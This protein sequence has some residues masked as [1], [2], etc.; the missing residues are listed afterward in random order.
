MQKVQRN[1]RR[2]GFGE[3]SRCEQIRDTGNPEKLSG[4]CSAAERQQL[5]LYNHL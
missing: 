5:Q 3:A 2:V 4:G 1:E